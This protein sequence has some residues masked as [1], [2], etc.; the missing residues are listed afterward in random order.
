MDI[1]DSDR[2]T[3]AIPSEL[4]GPLP[5]NVRLN[6]SDSGVQFSV[7][8]IMLFLV[9]GGIS[10][11][12]DAFD[13]VRQFQHR[14][15]LR[16]NGRDVLGVVTGFSV[17]RWAPKAVQYS[18][19]FNG[20]TYSGKAKSSH[21]E[22]AIGLSVSDPILVRFLATDPAINHPEAWEWSALI[23]LDYVAF[24]VFLMIVGIPVLASLLR[25]RR[26]ARQG[27]A[28]QGVVTSCVGKDGAF[29]LEYEFRTEE[30][31][32]LK[33]KGGST[34]EFGAGATIWI[35]YWPR[36]PQRNHCYPLSLFDIVE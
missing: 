28:A 26:L 17:H 9:G 13:D 21:S 19:A 22:P 31:V 33:G 18:F 12:W 10:V 36:K 23:G 16:S 20:V 15:E 8:F 11:G 5:R 4:A 1:A 2:A 24:K 25:A 29:R 27:K 34:D 35:L 14:T 32:L 7:W 6:F 3:L 30:G